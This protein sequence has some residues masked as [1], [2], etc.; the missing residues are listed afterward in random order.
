MCKKQNSFSL[1]KAMHPI[2]NISATKMTASVKTIGIF[3]NLF[4]DYFPAYTHYPQLS[5]HG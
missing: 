3:P 2:Y 5:S 4:S 1:I